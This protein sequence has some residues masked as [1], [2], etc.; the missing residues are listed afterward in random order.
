MKEHVEKIIAIATGE[1]GPSLECDYAADAR[2]HYPKR[3]SMILDEARLILESWP[4]YERLVEAANNLVNGWHE[5]GPIVDKEVE[6]VE[7]ALKA[8]KEAGLILESCPQVERVIWAAESVGVAI[9]ATRDETHPIVSPYSG[10]TGHAIR[11][12]GQGQE[13][14]SADEM[15]QIKEAIAVLSEY[16]KWL[17]LI[18]KAKGVDVLACSRSINYFSSSNNPSLTEAS[19]NQLRSLLESIPQ[20]K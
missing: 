1:I 18:E 16:P 13:P 12:P 8:I 6:S 10:I 17:P 19:L 20:E 9:H 7:S 5:H 15:G 11:R 3:I 2:Y 4:L 14:C